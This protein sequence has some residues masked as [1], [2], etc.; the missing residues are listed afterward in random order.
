MSLLAKWTWGRPLRAI[1]EALAAA[2][3]A[4]TSG[5]LAVVD[6]PQAARLLSPRWPLFAVGPEVRGRAARRFGGRALRAT[7][8]ALPL[9]PGALAALVGTGAVDAEAV[10]AWAQTVREGGLIVLVDR[11]APEEHTRRALCAGLLDLEQR[12]AGRHVVTSGRVRRFA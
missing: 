6:A 5:P 10:T 8:A 11:V 3:I 12:T 1:E 2:G 4:P 9:A 7:G